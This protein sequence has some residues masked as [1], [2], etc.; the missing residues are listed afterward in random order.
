MLSL[1]LEVRFAAIDLLRCATVDPRVGSFFAEEQY[2]QTIPA[3]IKHVNELES[4]PHNLRLVT[5]HLACNLFVTPLYVKQVMQARYPL[6]GLLIQLITSSLLDTS[7][8]TT[9]VASASLAFNLVASNFRIRR[10]EGHEGLSESKQVE[11]AAGVIE[12]LSSEQNADAKK[13]LLLALGYLVYCAPQEGE[14]MDL[15]KALDAK[16]IVT[17]FGSNDVLSKEVA[18]LL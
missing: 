5:I 14:L 7:H 11:L 2:P 4:C 3:L 12:T 18:S 6:A 1:P 17:G 15:T 9:R 10:E 13:A 16:A 8:P